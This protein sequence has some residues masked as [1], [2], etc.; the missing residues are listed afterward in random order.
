MR[1]APEDALARGPATDVGRLAGGT[2]THRVRALR[3]IATGRLVLAVCSLLA[4][5]LDPATQVR[6]AQITYGLLAGYALYALGLALIAWLTPAPRLRLS[7]VIHV[8]D[9]ALFTVFL[10]LTDGPASPVF[11]YF[12]FALVAATVRWQWRGALWTAAVIFVAFNAMGLYQAKVVRDPGVDLDR[13]LIS[14]VYLVV[15]A[16]L[17]AFLGAY[18]DRRRRDMAR[19]AAWPRA[20]P[21]RPAA[22]LREM[23]ESAAR[24]LDAPRVLLLWEDADEPWL[25]LAL[26]AGPDEFRSWREPPDTFPFPTPEPLAQADFLCR[27]VRARLPFVLRT[28]PAGLEEWRGAPLDPALRAR[29]AMTSVLSLRV[30]GD[31]FDGRLLALDKR[32]LTADDLMLGE[33]VARQ[34]AASLDHLLLSRRVQ[35]AAVAEERMRVSRNL[36]D[37]VLQSLAGAALKLETIR[38]LVRT[39]PELARDRLA[40]VQRLIAHEQRALRLFI[41]DPKFTAL[42]LALADAPLDCQ[43]RDLARRLEALWGVRVSLELEH[44]DEQRVNALADDVP[45]IVQEAVVNAARH[46]GASEVGVRAALRNGSLCVTVADNGRGFAFRGHYDHAALAAL[47]RG[48]VM[49]KERVN[50]LGGT[51]AIDST[52]GGARLE[53]ELPCPGAT[54]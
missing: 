2:H 40:D 3:L 41:Q 27:D 23:L 13:F 6:Y 50:T 38:W 35:Q 31:C 28:A 33:V 37:G 39:E 51:L 8:V 5:R 46:G 20:L 11:S 54:A 29:F 24:V 44:L 45:H 43:L 12:A 18:E 48:P 22:A 21:P 53:I 10:Y 52:S 47:R 1:A 19:L 42:S 30:P 4:V 14:S 15:L 32:S 17:L 26:W 7:V 49:L 25:E 34:V 36:H 9:L 16:S